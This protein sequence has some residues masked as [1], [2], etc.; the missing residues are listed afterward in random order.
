MRRLILLPVAIS[1]G[2]C[3]PLPE[4]LKEEEI[5]R[6]L[7]SLTYVPESSLKDQQEIHRAFFAAYSRSRVKLLG[8]EDLEAI[9]GNLN[10]LRSRM[11]DGPS[12]EALAREHP[13]VR[14]A[15]GSHMGREA[16]NPQFPETARLLA[17]TPG[18]RLELDEAQDLY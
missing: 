1:L 12:A 9:T 11:G 3:S 17:A 2:A 10:E 7:E 15:V 4:P 8:G 5:G 6:H 18:Y 13:A 14:S 16:P